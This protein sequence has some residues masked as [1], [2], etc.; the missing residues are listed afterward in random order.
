MSSFLYRSN[1][2]FYF[3]PAFNDDLLECFAVQFDMVSVKVI[4]ECGDDF[5][6]VDI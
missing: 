3:F 1:D 6:P 2:L 5:F 4:V